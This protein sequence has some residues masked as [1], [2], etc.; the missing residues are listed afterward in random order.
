MDT[1]IRQ[2]ARVTRGTHY[3]YTSGGHRLIRSVLRPPSAEVTALRLGEATFG[4]YVEDG[5]LFF[6]CCI[7]NGPWAASHYNWWLNP[8]QMRPDPLAELGAGNPGILLPV[9]LVDACD[10]AVAATAT[11]LI[12]VEPSEILRK[13]VLT[14]IESVLDPWDHLDTAGRVLGRHPDMSWMAADALWI[15]C[16]RPVQSCECSWGAFAWSGC[17]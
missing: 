2:I 7:G 9:E 11:F 16:G 17:M 12:S 8:Q 13:C 10:G 1:D 14:Q 4:L 15:E 3:N 5:V 6:L